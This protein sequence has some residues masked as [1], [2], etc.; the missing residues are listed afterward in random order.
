MVGIKLVIGRPLLQFVRENVEQHFGIRIGIDVPQVL[1]EQIAF[2][3]IGIGQVA[4]VPEHEAERR[5]DVERLRFRGR[6]RRARCGVTRVPDAAGA[7]QAAHIAG[8]EDVAHHALG[9]VHEELALQQRHDAGGILAAMLQHEEPV[10]EHL[11]DRVF[12]HHA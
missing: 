1:A 11:V 3:L 9:L 12:R 2:E 8:A 4:V 6:P 7:E 10:V 5:I